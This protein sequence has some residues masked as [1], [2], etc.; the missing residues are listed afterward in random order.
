MLILAW[1]VN[2]AAGPTGAFP[3]RS[4]DFGGFGTS[5]IIAAFMKSLPVTHS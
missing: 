3:G 4:V 2:P 1:F 5:C